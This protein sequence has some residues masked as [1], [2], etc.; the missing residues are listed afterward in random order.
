MI[1]LS[2]YNLHVFETTEAV[3]NAAAEFIIEL[4]N[5]S[6]VER[7]RFTISLSGGE[8]PKKVYSL[9]SEP[10]FKDQVQW[11]RT[12]IFWGDERFV[13]FND[14]RNNGH[15][16]K[17]ILL[18]KIEIPLGNIH[19]VP[20]NSLPAE[21]A[22]EYEKEIKDFFGEEPTRFDLIL[23]GLGENGH[24]AS[25]FPGTKVIDEH[26]EGIK[27]VYVEEE[28]MFRITMTA[29]LINEA[30]N[31]LFLVTGEEKATI[32]ERVLTG[33]YEP[34]IYP[35]QLI[36]PVNGELFWFSDR[37]AADLIT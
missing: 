20:V 6:I 10:P 2:K 23:L 14:E 4:A 31:I 37:A 21:A 9:L 29:P 5:K 16:A 28:R 3:N 7:G 36:K 35:T 22:V 11:K 17:T 12:F 32:L 33:P 18:D 19:F 13:P 27:E 25:L 1:T 8:T 34:N 24:T 15:Q 26:V 30:H